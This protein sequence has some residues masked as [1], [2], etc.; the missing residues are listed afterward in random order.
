MVL[1][2]ILQ[3]SVVI[4]GPFR[5]PGFNKIINQWSERVQSKNKCFDEL[6]VLFRYVVGLHGDVGDIIQKPSEREVQSL[7]EG[8]LMIAIDFPICQG[9]FQMNLVSAVISSSR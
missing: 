7:H 5:W 3:A 9:P 6:T 8:C 1:C 4:T 2:E